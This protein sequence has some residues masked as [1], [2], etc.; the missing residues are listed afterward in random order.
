MISF[1]GLLV[2]GTNL[3]PKYRSYTVV[4]HVP[5]L[6]TV[7][8]PT[9][10]SI[11]VQNFDQRDQILLSYQPVNFD[12]PKHVAMHKL[13]DKIEDEQTEFRPRQGQVGAFV[14][15]ITP[16]H[17][18]LARMINNGA[19]YSDLERFANK[20]PGKDPD[21]PKFSGDS[22]RQYIGHVRVALDITQQDKPAK[23]RLMLNDVTNHVPDSPYP[24]KISLTAFALHPDLSSDFQ[25]LSSADFYN[26]HM[27]RYHEG[28]SYQDMQPQ[29]KQTLRTKFSQARG[30]I[31]V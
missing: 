25:N 23:E 18:Q 5:L 21:V 28:K 29:E 19:S 12:S 16:L 30:K 15:K 9:G 24:G 26:K 20:L 31:R 14:Y 8:Q 7:R 22:L 2:E 27:K 4:P 13:I 1:K 11:N 6:D 10:K 17:A 3:N